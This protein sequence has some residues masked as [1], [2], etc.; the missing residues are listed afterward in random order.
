MNKINPSKIW[1]QQKFNNSCTWDCLSMLLGKKGVETSTFN[2]V[3]T[4]LIPYQ[5][6]L[7]LNNKKVSSK[8]QDKLHDSVIKSSILLK[9]HLSN[10]PF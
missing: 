4:S 9:E 5:I 7:N 10:I 1:C 3:A 8:L 2:I 6:K